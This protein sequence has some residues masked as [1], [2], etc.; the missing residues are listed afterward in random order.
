MSNE[1]DWEFAAGWLRKRFAYCERVDGVCEAADAAIEVMKKIVSPL[2]DWMDAPIVEADWKGGRSWYEPIEY[3]QVKL[4]RNRARFHWTELENVV[5]H[6]P[7]EERSSDAP[8]LSSV[9]LEEVI[10]ASPI[11]RIIHC[12]ITPSQVTVRNDDGDHVYVPK[13]PEPDWREAPYVRARLR[14]VESSYLFQRT[15]DGRYWDREGGPLFTAEEFEM[16]TPLWPGKPVNPNESEK[17]GE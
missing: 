4:V 7:C 11:E 8:N 14:Q 6:Y 16:I 10:E 5:P 9:G 2:P 13:E 15:S 1:I 12:P 17:S 3:G